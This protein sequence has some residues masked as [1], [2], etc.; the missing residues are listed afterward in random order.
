MYLC[1][2]V[3]THLSFIG[4]MN[5]GDEDFEIHNIGE[6]HSGKNAN[7]SSSS[8]WSQQIGGR[9]IGMVIIFI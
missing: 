5:S 8:S 6:I 9:H 4:N 7:A 3:F 1:I 2:N